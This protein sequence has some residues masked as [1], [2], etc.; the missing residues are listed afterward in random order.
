M[1]REGERA[2]NSNVALE[3]TATSGTLKYE[4]LMYSSH[5]PNGW[6]RAVKSWIVMFSVSRMRSRIASTPP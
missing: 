5:T 2:Y 3:I 6:K 4:E 1:G